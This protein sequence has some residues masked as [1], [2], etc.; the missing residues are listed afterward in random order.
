[1]TD[2]ATSVLLVE[3]DPIYAGLIQASLAGSGDQS[4]RVAWVRN[5]AAALARLGR[6]GVEVVL[7]DL[8][9][10][11]SQGI[12]AFEQV[13]AAAPDASIIVLSA[14]GDEQTA[15]QVV[16]RGAHDYLVKG[17]VDGRWLLRA[18][19]YLRGCEN[20]PPSPPASVARPV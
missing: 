13:F 5:L 12:A 9:L 17:Q 10:P 1:M 14:L 8:A 6:E 15:R 16:Q 2:T 19:L 7:L 3:E 4:F 11:D 20:I 18:L